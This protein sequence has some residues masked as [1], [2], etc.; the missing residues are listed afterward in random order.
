MSATTRAMNRTG[1]SRVSNA[2]LPDVGYSRESA[3][4]LDILSSLVHERPESGGLG[5]IFRRLPESDFGIDGY[6]EVVGT[7][8]HPTAAT[9]RFIAVQVKAGPSYFAHDDGDSWSVYVRRI[10]ANHW[11][12]SSLPVLLVL[13]D[14]DTDSCYWVRAD[15]VW[16][17]GD[18]ETVRFRVPHANRLGAESRDELR[19]VAYHGLP[20]LRELIDT[21]DIAVTRQGIIARER[22]AATPDEWLSIAQ[23]WLA[24]SEH[25]G[26]RHR[27][28]Q[29]AREAARAVHAF[30]RAG[31]HERARVQLTRTLRLATHDL[32]D[33]DVVRLIESTVDVPAPFSVAWPDR[34]SP[35]D[36]SHWA[37][38]FVRAGGR[39]LGGDPTSIKEAVAALRAVSNYPPGEEGASARQAEIE[40]LAAVTAV[41]GEDHGAAAT[42]FGRAASLA[43]E[44]ALRGEL[45]VRSHLHDGL[46]GN[47]EPA[48]A[49]LAALTVSTRVEPIRQRAIAWLLTL[50]GDAIG[51][52]EAFRA[53]AHVAGRHDDPEAL[54]CGLRNAGWAERRG[55]ISRRDLE[56]PGIT[57][58]RVQRTLAS[59]TPERERGDN[60][61][62]R[63]TQALKERE[64]PVAYRRALAARALAFQDVDPSLHDD[65]VSALAECWRAAA[66]EKPDDDILFHAVMLT[67]DTRLT[68]QHELTEETLRPFYTV[69]REHMTPALA[70]RLVM[71]LTA[72]SVDSA[73]NAGRLRALVDLAD[74]IPAPLVPSRII[75]TLLEALS[76]GPRTHV[77]TDR[78]TPACQL[79]V[80]VA[81]AISPESA[82]QIRNAL[83]V[84][85][86]TSHG[87]LIGSLV[88][89]LSVMIARTPGG[90]EN[91]EILTELLGLLQQ[92]NGTP[93]TATI[94]AALAQLAAGDQ[95]EVRR[96]VVELLEREAATGNLI[97]VAML[98]AIGE[99]PDPG[100]ATRYL[101]ALTAGLER[102]TAQAGSGSLGGS[103]GDFPTLREWAAANATQEARKAVLDAAI[104]L[105]QAEGHLVFTRCSWMDF[106]ASMALH[107]ADRA[108]LRDIFA[109]IAHNGMRESEMMKGV[110]HP[111]GTI[112][113]QTEDASDAR[114]S[115]LTLL[116]GL[117]DPSDPDSC[118]LI[119][120]ALEACAT[121]R[122]PRIRD[123]TARI[124]GRWYGRL[125]RLTE[126][127][128]DPRVQGMRRILGGLALDRSGRVRAAAFE[129]I[130][131]AC[132]DAL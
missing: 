102:L 79:V 72:Q 116:D 98:N 60:L 12:A 41:L 39:A 91:A 40:R 107:A 89:A 87:P 59:R 15:T 74:C 22:T 110:T 48:L 61:L 24:F 77:S 16:L 129:A 70:A 62:D 95:G 117:S 13:V 55:G 58:D 114:I 86:P 123:S 28:R 45:T 3:R 56:Q 57:A 5:W 101:E 19:N 1:T 67:A 105:I 78:V 25:L 109:D 50:A 84:L 9:G 29:S 81:G 21:A 130:A 85:A 131:R 88:R 118:A 4:G 37:L 36:E 51:S 35:I 17:E 54:E 120:A 27:R 90:A 113:F 26:S 82:A 38:A 31:A 33:P 47:V 111:L 30:L 42:L 18:G 100:A 76:S 71:A 108:R 2:D 115:A 128:S 112:R 14:L 92:W 93:H 126:S 132:D 69:V 122:D 46:A 75:P 127:G 65:A 10:T 96:H 125:L 121:D 11:S 20:P 53:A 97:A 64:L 80:A 44:E 32:R 34:G 7:L 8:K 83:R 99:K 94:Y 63:S 68:S 119:S 43:S 23:D 49:R 106:A 103:G 52:A 73:E 124:T 104:A 66:V 6:I